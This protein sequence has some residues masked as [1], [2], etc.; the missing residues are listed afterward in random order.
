MKLL[1]ELRFLL[2]KYSKYIFNIF[3]FA[4]LFFTIVL[5]YVFYTDF[6]G[7]N[8]VNYCYAFFAGNAIAA[9]CLF[10]LGRS[11]VF[12]DR[13]P[14]KTHQ[15]K[16]YISGVTFLTAALVGLAMSGFVYFEFTNS[17]MSEND[18]FIKA[19]HMLTAIFLTFG[20]ILSFVAIINFFRWLK[21]ESENLLGNN[22]DKT[23]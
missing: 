15:K 12:I 18:F 2:F 1:K 4:L 22:G 9:N 23:E 14:N 7:K 21:I 20:V 11:N 10:S 3:L 19:V 16:I 8:L 5:I 6:K 17:A 13:F